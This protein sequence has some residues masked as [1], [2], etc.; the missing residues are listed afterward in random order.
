MIQ[1]PFE[2]K[3]EDRE[4]EVQ[5]LAKDLFMESKT[6]NL[7]SLQTLPPPLTVMFHSTVT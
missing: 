3:E 2:V 4:F 7:I 5:E 1:N 6:K